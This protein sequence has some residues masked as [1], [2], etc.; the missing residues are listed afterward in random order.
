MEEKKTELTVEK[1]YEK[2]LYFPSDVHSLKGQAP[3]SDLDEKILSTKPVEQNRNSCH[4]P[5]VDDMKSNIIL[6]YI[7]EGRSWSLSPWLKDLFGS[8]DNFLHDSESETLE[9]FM[10][11]KTPRKLFWQLPFGHQRLKFGLKQLTKKNKKKSLCWTQYMSLD[12][13]S[14]ENLDN[15]I[16]DTKHLLDS[17]QRTCLAFDILEKKPGMD[18]ERILIFFSLGAPVK[19][20]LLTDCVGRK[21]SFPFERCRKWEVGFSKSRSVCVQLDSAC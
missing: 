7:K 11:S 16:R 21:F 17:R 5:S 2:D 1:T 12:A 18:D 8:R 10:Y 20:V 19:P 15:A 14:L 9:A 6:P 13:Q 4:I 3:Q